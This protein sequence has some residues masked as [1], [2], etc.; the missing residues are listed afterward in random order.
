MSE[1]QVLQSCKRI[2]RF[3]LDVDRMTGQHDPIVDELE[4]AAEIHQLMLQDPE[5]RRMQRERNLQLRRMEPDYR[6]RKANGRT[7]TTSL[8]AGAGYKPK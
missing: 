4:L 1:Q 8:G 7:R 5:V 2:V 6:E 3:N